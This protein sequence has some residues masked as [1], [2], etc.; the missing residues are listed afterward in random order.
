MDLA[1][2]AESVVLNL[3]GTLG[4][5]YRWKIR[6]VLEKSKPTSPNMTKQ[7]FKALKSLK[8]NK[9]IR[10]LQADKGNCTVLLD[11]YEYR[12]K[13][14]H[15]WILGCTN[16]CPKIQQKPWREKCKNSSLNKRLLYPLT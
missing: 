7:E 15:Y 12:N 3:P 8:L 5:E 10:I 14:N 1:C 9:D 11:E 4:M 13:L 16:H 6:S 2:A